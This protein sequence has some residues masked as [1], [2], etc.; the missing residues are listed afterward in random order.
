MDFTTATQSKRFDSMSLDSNKIGKG[1]SD[2]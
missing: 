2:G 1:E